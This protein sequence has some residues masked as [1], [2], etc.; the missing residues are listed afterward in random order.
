MALSL[1]FLI[2]GTATSEEACAK[3]QAAVTNGGGWCD[4]CKVGYVIQKVECQGCYQAMTAKKGGWCERCQVG[5][6]DGKKIECK[7]CFEGKEHEHAPK[8]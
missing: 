7:D 6:R 1:F 2:S 5:Y 3:C 8:T 4:D